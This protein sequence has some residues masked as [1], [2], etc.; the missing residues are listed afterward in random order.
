M[1]LNI[2]TVNKK[3]QL[4]DQER[5]F[6]IFPQGLFIVTNMVFCG[7]IVFSFHALRHKVEYTSGK[8]TQKHN[9]KETTLY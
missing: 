7:V 3:L 5:L 9:C 1:K 2:I 8:R 6:P 4:K